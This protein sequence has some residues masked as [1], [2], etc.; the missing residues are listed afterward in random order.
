MNFALL[1]KQRVKTMIIPANKIIVISMRQIGDVLLV[2]PLLNSLRHAYPYAEIDVVVFQNKGEMLDGNPHINQIVEVAEKLNFYQHYQFI[3]TIFRRY[4]LA[5][6]T[7]TGDRPS[8]YAWLAAPYRVNVVPEYRLQNAWKYWIAQRWTIFDDKSQHT[9]LQ[10]LQLVDLMDIPRYYQVIPPRTQDTNWQKLLPFDMVTTNYV[11]L[12][13]VPRWRY[14]YW[15]V[16]GWKKLIDELVKLKL[17]IVMTGSQHPDELNYIQQV[18]GEQSHHVINLAGQLAF[19]QITVLLQNSKLYVGPD[20]AV[21]H[22]AAATGVPCVALFGPTNPVKWAPFPIHYNATDNP[23]LAIG[24][25]QVNNVYL[26]QT[27]MECVPCHQ[28]GCDRHVMSESRCLV[29]LSAD[30]V[31]EVVRAIIITPV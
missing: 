9:V 5:I 4:D 15:T 21:T 27:Q 6:S 17:K 12:H 31:I 28:E 22:L 13:L 10:N 29:E 2:T 24:S 8:F 30:K 20:T 16:W 19:K 23:F 11:V 3:K 18:L 14:K 1:S 26:L 25:Q 7:Q